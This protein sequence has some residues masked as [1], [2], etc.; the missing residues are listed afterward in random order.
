MTV[1]CTVL[2][3]GVGGKGRSI[4]VA[5]AAVEDRLVVAC[6]SIKCQLI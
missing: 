1:Q 5:I 4:G 6:V 3:I 2:P